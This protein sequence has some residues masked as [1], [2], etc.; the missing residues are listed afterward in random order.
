MEADATRSA[1]K[2]E[3]VSEVEAIAD[4]MVQRRQGSPPRRHG[5]RPVGRRGEPH[6]GVVRAAGLPCT[7]VGDLRACPQPLRSLGQHTLRGVAPPGA[8][9]PAV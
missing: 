2:F 9:S 5:Y 6:R 3:E 4:W 1:N 8:I 7:D